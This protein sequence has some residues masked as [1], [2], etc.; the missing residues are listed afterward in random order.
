MTNETQTTVRAL[1][2][3][4]RLYSAHIDSDGG[5]AIPHTGNGYLCGPLEISNL[6]AVEKALEGAPADLYSYGWGGDIVIDADA[7]VPEEYAAAVVEILDSLESHPALA[8]DRMSELEHESTVEAWDEYGRSDLRTTL[9]VRARCGEGATEDVS[10]DAL[11]ALWYQWA[12]HHPEGGS[13]HEGYH[14]VHFYVN[15]AAPAIAVQLYVL[16]HLST[17]PAWTQR[18]W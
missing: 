14:G 4:A 6:E 8:E 15:Q 3:G 10:D 11:D 12:E 5:L 13:V 17:F 16:G 9:E 1:L 2:E 18:A 7:E